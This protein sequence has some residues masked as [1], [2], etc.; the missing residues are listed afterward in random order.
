MKEVSG[1]GEDFLGNSVRKM[2][3]LLGRKVEEKLEMSVK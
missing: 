3:D 1:L 2:V